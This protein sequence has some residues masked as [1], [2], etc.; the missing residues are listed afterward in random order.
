[1]TLP[2]LLGL[3]FIIVGV[4]AL[5]R[6][7]AIM[8]AVAQLAANRPLLFVVALVEIMAGL[9]V[10][11]TYPTLSADWMGLISVIGWMLIIEGVV[12]LS[13][14]NKK[15]QRLIRRFN[16]QSWYGAGGA[17]AIVLGGYLAAVG[18][19]LIS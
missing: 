2:Q 3:Y 6:R 12:Y 17:L 16:T 8:P 18:F 7:K 10:I 15:V 9:A 4:I 5:Y 1:M 13:M 19:G 14:P 11:L